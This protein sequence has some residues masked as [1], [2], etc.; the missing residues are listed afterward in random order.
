[1]TTV[2]FPLISITGVSGVPETP[3]LRERGK[4]G[5]VELKWKAVLT[6]STFPIL[7]MVQERYNIGKHHSVH[8]STEWVQVAQVSRFVHLFF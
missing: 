5:V 1:M 6:N 4:A 8:H 2:T 3:T 7:Y